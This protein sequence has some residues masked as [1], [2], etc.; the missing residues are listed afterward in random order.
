MISNGEN[1][2][3]DAGGQGQQASPEGVDPINIASWVITIYFAYVLFAFNAN[4]SKK[5]VL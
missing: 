3:K 2:Q 5:V 4:V 1:K